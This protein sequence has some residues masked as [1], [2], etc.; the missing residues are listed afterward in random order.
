MLVAKFTRQPY[1]YI[2]VE[3]GS[4]RQQL[5]KVVVVGGLQLVLND[6]WSV[7]V[8]VGSENIQRIPAYVGFPLS[9]FQFQTECRSQLPGSSHM[10]PPWAV[11]RRSG[12]HAV[13]AV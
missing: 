6:N 9:Q 13:T 7:S 1:D 3:S 2:C 10:V 12:I 5:A 4:I 11:V 8:E